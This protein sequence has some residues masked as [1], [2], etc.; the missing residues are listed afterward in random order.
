MQ[1]EE[2]RMVDGNRWTGEHSA[3]FALPARHASSTADV[4]IFTVGFFYRGL[5]QH[6]E[7]THEETLVWIKH[8]TGRITSV[9]ATQ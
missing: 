6:K 9:S 2:K 5:Q 4:Y 7:A 8:S 1:Q 3:A